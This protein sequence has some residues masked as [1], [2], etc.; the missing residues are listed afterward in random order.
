MDFRTRLPFRVALALACVLGTPVAGAQDRQTAVQARPVALA[1][2]Q[3]GQHQAM[4]QVRASAR[5]AGPPPWLVLT[6]G[7]LLCAL[8]AWGG[9]SLA[10]RSRVR[11]AAADAALEP[12]MAV[13]L[14]ADAAP[15]LRPVPPQARAHV[16]ADPHHAAPAGPAGDPLLLPPAERLHSL[17]A[18]LRQQD[19]LVAIGQP[20]RAVR[21]LQVAAAGSQGDCLVP[22]LAL[23][24]LRRSLGDAE[25]FQRDWLALQQ[26]LGPV[27][28]GV[29]LRLDGPCAA[30]ERHPRLV[31][32]LVQAWQ[33]DDPACGLHALLF[34][35]SGDTVLSLEACDEILLLAQ[36]LMPSDEAQLPLHAPGSGHASADG[37]TTDVDLDL[38]AWE[39][40][41][42]ARASVRDGVGP[43]LEPVTP[44]R[45]SL[46]QGTARTVAAQAGTQ[47]LFDAAMRGER[48]R[49][50]SG[51]RMSRF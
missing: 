15:I 1:Q 44:S 33:S 41:T 13:G 25:G 23:L 29:L 49:A 26:R 4:T 38:G 40:S 47:A 6:G 22:W 10:G 2:A 39:R 14:A 12:V 16:P 17:A 32:A 3:A 34:E 20:L 36:L 7:G 37:D 28:A 9:W 46:V 24:A 45:L 51:G 35:R 50:R 11:R 19:M 5:P 42:R 18:L 27:P 31:Q 48:A 30:V 8:V 21:L 43:Q